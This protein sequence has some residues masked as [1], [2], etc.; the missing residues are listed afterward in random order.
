MNELPPLA[1]IGR[2]ESGVEESARANRRWW[3]HAAA[4][5]QAEHG[6]YLRDAGFMWCPEGLDEADARLLGPV[7]GKQI[8][9]VGGG[10]GQ[11][12]RWLVTQGATVASF[13]ISKCQLD[14]G[15]EL[16]RRSGHSVPLL[17][18]DATRIPF[19]N[20]SFDLAC[21]AFGAVPF[22][23]QPGL[24]MEEVFRVL[25]PG[26]RWAF[27]VNHPITWM[28]PDDPGPKGLTVK[29]SYFDPLP[30]LELDANGDAIYAEHHRTIGQR[31]RDIVAAGF[32]LTDI[33]EPQWA[34]GHDREWGQWSP[35]RGQHFPGTAI[36]V[37]DKPA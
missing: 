34:E 4:D 9:E 12:G 20:E 7:Q 1:S 33:V 28:F 17:Q 23:A 14:L 8:L 3:D 37:C 30:Y 18:A 5:Y 32:R 24:V 21:S 10:A 29:G 11:C 15:R 36:F 22:V 6:D 13:D 35:L 16:D 27:S 26:G 19:L 25:K 31:V 2:R